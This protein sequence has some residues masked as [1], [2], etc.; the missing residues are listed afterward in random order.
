MQVLY[1]QTHLNRLLL[2]E[3]R[4]M[5]LASI[6]IGMFVYPSHLARNDNP[7]NVPSS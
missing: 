2:L 5:A 7:M 1:R 6:V 4:A 3:L